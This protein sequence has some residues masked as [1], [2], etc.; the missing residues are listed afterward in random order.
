MLQISI[1]HE[2]KNLKIYDAKDHATLTT[3]TTFDSSKGF[4]NL[5]PLREYVGKTVMISHY[6]KKGDVI[7]FDYEQPKRLTKVDTDSDGMWFI[8]YE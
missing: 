5:A 8:E 4:I 3:L 7:T 6:N 2:G 1:L